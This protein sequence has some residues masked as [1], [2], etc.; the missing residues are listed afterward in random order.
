MD[1][2]EREVLMVAFL[3]ACVPRPLPAHTVDR[4]LQARGVLSEIMRCMSCHVAQRGVDP[5]R[6]APIPLT[7]VCSI[8]VSVWF[9]RQ[10][11]DIR[12]AADLDDR[13]A[14]E[15]DIAA[16]QAPGFWEHP[17]PQLQQKLAKSPHSAQLHRA[18]SAICSAARWTASLMPHSYTTSLR[19]KPEA[20]DLCGENQVNRA[21]E[22]LDSWQVGASDAEVEYQIVIEC[23]LAWVFPSPGEK[24]PARAAGNFDWDSFTVH[25]RTPS[26]RLPLSARDIEAV[27]NGGP[28]SLL[29]GWLGAGKHGAAGPKGPLADV[30]NRKAWWPHNLFGKIKDRGE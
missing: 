6:A 15:L 3:A 1:Q 27:M 18:A 26:E 9:R 22:T 12:A 28:G 20:F 2:N 29:E 25:S 11:Q 13:L 14:L 23:N 4:V 21:I 24:V 8:P 5:E 30:T 17:S 19:G 10:V 16:K 7:L